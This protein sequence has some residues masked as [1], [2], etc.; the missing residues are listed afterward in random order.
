[1]KHASRDQHLFAPGPKRILAL[2]GGGI[3]GMVTVGMLEEVEARLQSAAPSDQR[4]EFRLCD[5]FDLIVGTSTGSIIA[6]LLALG[7]SVAEVREHYLELGP[8]V[9]ARPRF[10]GQ[11]LWS[12]FDHLAFERLL[13]DKLGER[14]LDS[15]DLRTG[16]LITCKRVD[17]G[18]AW[19]LANNP[20]AMYWEFDRDRL[21]RDLVRA[22]TAAPSYFAPTEIHVGNGEV[23]LFL[24]GAMGGMNNPSVA[25][26]L[27]ATAA[28]YG[29]NWP[30][31]EAELSM[32][33]LGTGFLKP[34]FSRERFRGE[35]AAGQALFTLKGL[36]YE[37]QTSA[38]AVMQAFSNPV[39]PFEVNSEIKGFEKTLIGGRPLLRFQ[40]FDPPL[41][42]NALAQHLDLKLTK[43]QVREIA[44]MD[45]GSPGNVARLLAI[46]RAMAKRFPEGAF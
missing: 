22:S 31:G 38:V 33:S 26:F 10:L 34:V 21:L 44:S 15:V 12:K 36:M 7:A 14:R 23:G 40:R 28:E 41:D 5:H 30:T 46:G 19:I 37:S 4:D 1:M 3:R 20:R 27:Y 6:T 42:R 24:D 35:A 29:L 11:F 16:L 9:F 43:S 13:E 17:T 8:K 18:S 25:A 32:L 39:L 45:N 2:D